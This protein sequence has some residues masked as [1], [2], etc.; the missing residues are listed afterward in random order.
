MVP[1]ADH[2]A[3]AWLARQSR[4]YMRCDTRIAPPGIFLVQDSKEAVGLTPDNGHDRRRCFE[5]D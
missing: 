3:C 1:A 2:V 4:V 5:G